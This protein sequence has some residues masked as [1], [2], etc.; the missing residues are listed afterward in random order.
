[1]KSPFCVVPFVEG[2]TDNSTGKFRNCCTTDPRLT[3]EQNQSFSSWWHSHEFTNWKQQLWKQEFLPECHRCKVSEQIHGHSFRTAVNGQVEHNNYSWP[4]RWNINFGNTCNL[5]CWSC[6]ESA[7]N[8]IQ[9]HKKKAGIPFDNT[10]YNLE[11]LK[12]WQTL[13]HDIFKSYEIHD[14][15]TIT[16]LGGE[17]LYNKTVLNFLKSLIQQGYASRTRLEFHTNGTQAPGKILQANWKYVCMF[18]SLDA[19][20]KLAEWVRYGCRWSKVAQNVQ[21]L[22]ECSDYCEVHCVL[23]ILNIGNL[24]KLDEFCKQH[25]LPLKITVASRPEV[26]NIARW[27]KQ[28]QVL[29]DKNLLSDEHR[30]YYDLIGSQSLIGTSNRLCE[31]IQQF[32]TVRKPLEKFDINLAYSLGLIK[33]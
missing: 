16:I 33:H 15:V 5:A 24:H 29:C 10:D 31:W 27:D 30:P 4:S 11:F 7:S 32:C 14:H 17:P 6:H 25:N 8:V 2:F 21:L 20:D 18:I 19:V 1:M 22:K 13:E 3:S 9:Q 12:T 28:P 23:S 26:I